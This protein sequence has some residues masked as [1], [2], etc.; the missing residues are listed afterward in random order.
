MHSQIFFNLE[1]TCSLCEM[2]YWF[3]FA[4]ELATARATSAAGTI[5]VLIPTLLLSQT[6][7]DNLLFMYSF[8]V[9]F[10]VF[11]LYLHGLLAVSRKLLPQ[12]QGFAFSNSM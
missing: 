9:F 3:I 10:G 7:L 2:V 8:S 1:K 6:L 4:G 11:R 12:D 5:M